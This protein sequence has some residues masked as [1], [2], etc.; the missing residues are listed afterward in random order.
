[1]KLAALGLALLIAVVSDAQ[2]T[3][4]V[5]RPAGLVGWW[6]G[7]NNGKDSAGTNNGTV[8]NSVYFEPGEVGQCFHFVS[9]PNPRVYI[10]DNPTL[11]L[12]NSLTIE[13]WIKANFG[14]WIFN[15]GDDTISEVPYGITFIDQTSMI[16][17]FD[18]SASTTEHVSLTTPGP[19][20]T[21]VW[22]HIAATLDGNSGDMRLY[23]NGQVVAETT[24]SVRPTCPLTGANRSVCIGNAAGTAGFP[25][26]GWIDEISLYSRA[27]TQSEIQTIYAAGSAGKCAGSTPPFIL[28]QP[29]GQVGYWGRSVTFTVQATGDP[30]LDYQW[31]KDGFAITWA[32]NSSLVLT[33]LTLDAGGEY[34]VEVSNASGSVTSSN[35]LLTV[36]PAGVTLGLYAGL[37]I[38]GAAGNTYGIQYATNI[39]PTTVWSTLTQI[40]LTQ[41]VQLWMDTNVDIATGASPR[42]FYRV[43]AVP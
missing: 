10:P 40:T 22:L 3:N 32:T 34:S 17:S 43:V 7:E 6:R 30:V 12:T 18:V 23:V 25:F 4:C 9:T 33:N 42:R 15:R 41:P 14:Y 11:Q 26:D 8:I 19:L 13:G 2:T 24:T 20:P 16:L 36:N 5:P 35:A 38:E 28:V 37:T 21:N 31:Y 39:S 29:Q 1:M 27:L